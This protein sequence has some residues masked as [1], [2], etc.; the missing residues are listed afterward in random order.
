ML[1]PL[2]FLERAIAA[3]AAAATRLSACMPLCLACLP[4]LCLPVCLPVCPPA[5]LMHACMH[6]SP[7]SPPPTTSS[8]LLTPSPCLL[9]LLFLLFSFSSYFL[10]PPASLHCGPRDCLPSFLQTAPYVLSTLYLAVPPTLSFFYLSISFFSL[11][12]LTSVYRFF[13]FFLL[14]LSIFL[15]LC[16][17]SSTFVSSS[18]SSSSPPPSSLSPGLLY[19]SVVLRFL[20]LPFFAK[21][22]RLFVGTRLLGFAGSRYPSLLVYFRYSSLDGGRKVH[23][24]GDSI[25]VRLSSAGRTG[26]SVPPHVQIFF[27]QFRDIYSTAAFLFVSDA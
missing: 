8:F 20:V 17:L 21:E 24:A 25:L 7:P 5:C 16:R 11:H 26:G 3:A 15:L 1:S 22:T 2:P 12:F 9:L 19:S 10:H 14:L 6:V 18:S 13:S 27:A 4:P 23:A